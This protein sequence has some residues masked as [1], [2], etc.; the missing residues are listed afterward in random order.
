MHYFCGETRKAKI[1]RDFAENIETK[2]NEV[3][4]V[5]VCMHGLIVNP[6]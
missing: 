1:N 4:E 2:T 5:T 3:N 6:N